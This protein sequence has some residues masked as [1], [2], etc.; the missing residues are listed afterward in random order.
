VNRRQQ[1]DAITVDLA[2][3]QS[4]VERLK[5]NKQRAD[6][7]RLTDRELAFLVLLVRKARGAESIQGIDLFDGMALHEVGGGGKL[8]SFERL[9]GNPF[10]L[11]RLSDRE[12][13][14]F[15]RLTDKI[16]TL[17]P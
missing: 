4:R 16:E 7:S 6:Y 11:D 8:E 5:K 1:R 3:L 2:D 12:R 15:D 9:D 10:E 13:M 17:P 14:E